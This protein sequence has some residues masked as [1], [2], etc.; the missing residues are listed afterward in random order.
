MRRI[1][2]RTDEI[3]ECRK[4][5]KKIT[6]LGRFLQKMKSLMTELHPALSISQQ[7]LLMNKA[8][9]LQKIPFKIEVKVAGIDRFYFTFCSVT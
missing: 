5:L 3:F 9:L 6:I 7:F 1:K 8:T 2:N 4:K